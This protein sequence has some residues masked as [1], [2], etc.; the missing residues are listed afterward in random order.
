[1]QV[2]SAAEQLFFSTVRMETETAKE[3]GAGTGFFFDYAEGESRYPFVVSNKHV[4]QDAKR[5]TML[6][7]V[8]E[9]EQ[10]KI[11]ERF[12]VT[13]EDFGS[14]WF[15]H[16]EAD[17]DVAIMPL[18]PLLK[19]VQEKAGKQ[20][21]FKAVGS[22]LIPDEAAVEQLDAIEEVLFLGYPNALFDQVNLTPIARVGIT[23][24]PFALDYNGEKT[25]LID[26]SV[27]PGSSGSPVFILN[28]SSYTQKGGGIVIGS[29]LLFRGVLTGVFVRLETGQF[30]VVDIPT[31]QTP[32]VTI[33]QMIDLGLV[34]K[35]DVLVD[36]VR[37]FLAT[38]RT[39]S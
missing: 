38:V 33:E 34:Y 16:P 14:K 4:V 20:V 37:H 22:E 7:T 29:R 28:T 9:G 35:A 31:A 10:P 17:I 3:R 23:A 21:Y 27:F 2:Q 32:I 8:R 25:F 30:E 24:T 39:A 19:E 36:T 11:G 18:A 26:A 12:T 13:L 15:G 1:M 6:F 5:G